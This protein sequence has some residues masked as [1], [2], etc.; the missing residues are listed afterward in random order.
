MVVYT[1]QQCIEIFHLL[2]LR[3]LE[4]RMPK[5]FY[6]I[7]G[8]CNL[9]FFLKSIRYSEDLDLDVKT[10]AKNTLQKNV[11]KVLESVSFSHALQ[12]KGMSLTHV[13]RPKQTETTQRWKIQIKADSLGLPLPTKIE[14]S[15]RHFGKDILYEPIDPE[16]TTRYNLYQILATHYSK[17]EALKQKFEALLSRKETQARDIFDIHFLMNLQTSFEKLF[18]SIKTTTPRLIELIEG[19]SFDIFKAQVVAYLI[20]EYFSYYNSPKIWESVQS[21]VISK[22]RGEYAES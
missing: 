3:N 22:I 12:V 10:I 8:G 21:Q 18:S 7:K 19:V 4:S 1:P 9:R 15:R 20:P 5:S 2:F 16:L 14:F 11:N 17:S 13:S 6:A